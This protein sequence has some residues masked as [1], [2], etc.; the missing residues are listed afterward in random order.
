M[1]IEER[2]TRELSDLAR[3][4][5]KEKEQYENKIRD[6]ERRERVQKNFNLLFTSIE[7]WEAY[8]AREDDL[9]QRYAR[10]SF[11]THKAGQR[12][13]LM[14]LPLEV[15]SRIAALVDW[16]ATLMRVNKV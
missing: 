16:P 2:R 12:R 4:F 13:H 14:D 9:Q 3:A 1:T 7:A 11:S 5:D 15:L 6:D 10:Q 8:K